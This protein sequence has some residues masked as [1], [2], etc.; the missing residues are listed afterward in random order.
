MYL[1]YGRNSCRRQA[2]GGVEVLVKRS[3]EYSVSSA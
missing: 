2:Y 1:W 3:L